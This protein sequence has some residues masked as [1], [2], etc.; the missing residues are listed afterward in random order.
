MPF[1]FHH[2]IDVFT[3]I[4]TIALT[5]NVAFGNQVTALGTDCG[6]FHPCFCFVS[7]LQFWLKTYYRRHYRWCH[8]CS[9]SWSMLSSLPP[10]LLYLFQ[11]FHWLW[12]NVCRQTVNLFG[13]IWNVAM[14]LLYERH[15]EWDISVEKYSIFGKTCALL[16]NR[17]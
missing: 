2:F 12:R 1:I 10:L 7:C 8:F 9:N 17:K 14:D 13:I 5:F 6:S 3:I 11:T 15:V 4:V 16:F